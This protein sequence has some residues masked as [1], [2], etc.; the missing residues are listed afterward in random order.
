MNTTTNNSS[1]TLTKDY[2]PDTPYRPE[3]GRVTL[4]KIC[5]KCSK[6]H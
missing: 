5:V 6:A 1:S 3:S 4:T 2:G